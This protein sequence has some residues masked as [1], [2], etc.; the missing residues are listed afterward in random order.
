MPPSSR[1][2]PNDARILEVAAEHVRRLG[3]ARLTVLGVG[4]A[5]GMSHANVYRYFPSRAALLDAVTAQWLKPVEAQIAEAAEAQ[6]PAY[7]K[8]ERMFGALHRAY[9]EKLDRDPALFDLF[10]EA[11]E[12]DRPVARAHRARWT[13]HVQRVIEEGANA[14]SLAGADVRRSIALLFDSLHRFV[15]PVAIRL[16]K[17]VPASALAVRLE[18]VMRMTLRSLRDG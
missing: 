2:E 14:R 7:D 3:A 5:L 9:R 17:A 8:L 12:A 18:R 16:D 11:A 15:H 6:D 1:S 13:G 10:V 4:R